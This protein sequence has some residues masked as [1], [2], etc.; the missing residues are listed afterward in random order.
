MVAH[1]PN[2]CPRLS[3]LPQG[4][5]DRCVALDCAGLFA[6]D[7]PIPL[8]G[9]QHVPFAGLTAARLRELAPTIVILPLFSATHDAIAV[10]ETLQAFGFSGRIMVIAPN[11]PR[12]QLVERELR[13]AGPGTRLML[14]SP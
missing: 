7:G 3:D 1:P 4:A 8:N 13:A 2:A 11:L 14:V 6:P 9:V 5:D 12:P 10:V